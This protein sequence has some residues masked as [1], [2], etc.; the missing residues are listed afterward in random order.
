ML[1]DKKE[2]TVSIEREPHLA[3]ELGGGGL[4]EL[5]SLL[6]ASCADCL[7]HVHH[8]L[9][10]SSQGKSLEKPRVECLQEDD[11]VRQ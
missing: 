3:V 10:S 9:S 6:Q 8:P 2:S 7:Q 4:V 11:R 5:D 1:E